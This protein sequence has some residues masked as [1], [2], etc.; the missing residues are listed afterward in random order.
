M[1]TRIYKVVSNSGSYLVRASAR[2]QAIA[3][4]AKGEIAA[5][6]ATQEEIIE[7]ICKGGEVIDVKGGE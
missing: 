7:L 3:H 2:S 1:A 4:I 6:V 5:S